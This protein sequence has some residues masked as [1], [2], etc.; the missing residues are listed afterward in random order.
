MSAGFD[1]N[2][3]F[4]DKFMFFPTGQAVC[5]QWRNN[6]D[7]DRRIVQI[8]LEEDRIRLNIGSSAGNSGADL[9]DQWEQ[10]GEIGIKANGQ[11]YRYSLLSIDRS[12][13]YNL[14]V[15]AKFPN[16]LAEFS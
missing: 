2:F 9:S 15:S 3:E 14:V 11:T 16:R 1:G 13:A 12:D 5:G 7:A 10:N 6:A 8:D 4:A